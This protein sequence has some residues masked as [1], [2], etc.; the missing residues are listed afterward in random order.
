MSTSGGF[1]PPAA[2]ECPYA[3][4]MTR[5]AALA[6]RAAG[7]LLENCVVV[8]TDG[9]VIGTAGSTSPTEVELN[10]VSPTEFGAT[11]R[12]HTAFAASAWSGTYDI[13]L[14]T[15]GSITSLTDDW[16]NVVK[17]PDADA[18][19]VHTQ[20]PWHRGATNFRDNWV[21]DSTLTGWGAGTAAVSRNRLINATV[22]LTGDWGFSDN[23]VQGGTVTLTQAT[24]SRSFNHNTV[25]SAA[26][27]RA[28]AGATGAT[29]ITDSQ[30][31]DGYV[32]EIAATSTAAVTLD[33]SV[34]TGHNSA[35]LDCQIDGS[36][37]R[38][39]NDTQS[40]AHGTNTQYVLVGAGFVSIANGCVMNGARVVRDPATTATIILAQVRGS[41][42]V[43]QAAGATVGALSLSAS[44]LEV[45]GTAITQNGPGAITSNTSRLAANISN[46]A[47][48]TR[49]LTLNSC[50]LAGGVLSQG[51]TGGTGTD[52]LQSLT[53]R[54][55]QSA[56]ILQGAT[57][58]GGNQTVINNATVESGAS[59]T[60]T[61]PVGSAGTGICIQ[62]SHLSA[63]ALITGTGTGLVTGCRFSA[64][65]SVNLGAF[66][67]DQSVA[68]GPL[69]ITATASNSGRLANKSFNDWI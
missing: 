48:A 63:N 38:S 36:G 62:N 33:G 34:F 40:Y 3:P 47:T 32:T 4:R 66:A 39:I 37:T 27:V 42:S 6:L 59:L 56:V 1:T 55:S 14:G 31:L 54:A 5:A 26:V 25:R 23:H 7:G 41:G 68:E 43:V 22:D 67:H 17:D 18:P 64:H 15:A 29:F 2:P 61:D 30:F 45:L 35:A 69:T 10:P 21:E 49:G 8:I 11:A 58:P 9:P 24:G 51:R 28:L 13:D 46:T 19:T 60:L 50:D 65:C 44:T 20:F 57:D 16:G 12:V 53:L 52:T